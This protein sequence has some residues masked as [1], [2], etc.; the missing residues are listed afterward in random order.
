MGT[1]CKRI[2]FVLNQAPYHSKFEM[3]TKDCCKPLITKFAHDNGY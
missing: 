3:L 1:E 2:C